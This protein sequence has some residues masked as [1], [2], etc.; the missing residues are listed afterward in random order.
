MSEV[1]KGF[2]KAV[3]MVKLDLPEDER[4]SL[5]QQLGGFMRWLEPLLEVET[6]EVEPM[7][8]G[9]NAVNVLRKDSVHKSAAA[10]LQETAPEFVEGF[11][12][13][14]PIIE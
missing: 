10:E 3:K 13:V 5:Y 1:K 12:L 6:T 9:H 2:E 4:E 11:Y 14:P 7:L 8:L